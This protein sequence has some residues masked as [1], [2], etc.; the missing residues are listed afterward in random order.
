MIYFS[1]KYIY[2]GRTNIYDIVQKYVRIPSLPIFKN[3]RKTRTQ[4]KKKESL[5][6]NLFLL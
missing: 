6:L 1:K 2:K 3:S 5:C 4:F